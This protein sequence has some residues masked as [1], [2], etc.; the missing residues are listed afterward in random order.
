LNN[1]FVITL[2][3]LKPT[4]ET[5]KMSFTPVTMRTLDEF[6]RDLSLKPKQYEPIKCDFLDRFRGMSWAE[7]SYLLEDEEEA[8]LAAEQAIKDA[9][10]AKKDAEKRLVEREELRQTL[11]ERKKLYQAGLYDLEEGEELDM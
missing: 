4:Y 3:A 5:F 6:G 9:E 2:N 7:M 1:F 10:Q 8:E 11:A